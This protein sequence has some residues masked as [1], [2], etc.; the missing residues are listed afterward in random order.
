MKSMK[1]L[2]TAAF[3]LMTV[4]GLMAQQKDTAT[5]VYT[6]T[7]ELLTQQTGR[8]SIGGY[9]EVHYNQPLAADMKQAGIL[10]VHR[11]VMFLGYNFSR[12]TQFVSEVEF[13]YTNELWVEQAY[14]QHRLNRFVNFRAG[15]LLIPMGIINEYHE[16]VTFNGVERPI[17]D[18][19]IAPSTW[20]EIGMG[21]A[22]TILPAS[23][24]YQA[25]VVNGF[26]GYDTKGVFSADK[27]LR[28]GRQKGSKSY[29]TA[30]NFAGKIEYYG[31]SNLN[32]GL[33]GYAGK[34][35]SRLMHKLYN[36]STHLVARADSSVV[37]I[38]MVGAD[39]RFEWKGFE[40]RGQLYYAGISNTEQYNAFTAVNGKP[41]NLGSAMIG[42]YAEVGYNVLRGCKNTQRELIPFVRYEVYDTHYK[43]AGA[44]ERNPAYEN[45]MITSGLTL[46]LNQGAVLKADMQLISNSADKSWSKV[47]NAGI[48]VMF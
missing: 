2:I 34:S 37:G 26:N 16:P 1:Q 42:Y 15:L 17:I 21:F 30:P 48:G 35:Q 23:L 32:L 8:L 11:L 18:N 6:N 33:S 19:R 5:N 14:L 39:A 12:E 27:G 29:I 24:K 40:M 45:T 3:I 22:G 41:N 44:L 28:D 38:A 13:E 31:I 20:R 4:S 36:D 7:A 46:K 9:G 10:D 43:T 47:F 25:Y